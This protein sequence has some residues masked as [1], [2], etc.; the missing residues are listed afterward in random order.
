[1]AQP[2]KV[3]D[4]IKEL[5]RVLAKDLKPS[6]LNWRTHSEAQRS[7]MRGILAEIGYAGAALA[8]ELPDGGLELIDGHLRTETTPDMMI[9]VL[10]LDVSQEEAAKILATFDPLG[11]L[12]GAD[13]VALEKLLAE[14]NVHDPAL[15]AMLDDVAA[16]AGLAGDSDVELKPVDVRPPPAMT[17]ALIGIP[18][19]R[20]GEIAEAVNMLGSVPGIILETTSND[21]RDEG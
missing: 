20:F 18:T 4:R 11:T 14:V 9:P 16:D 7:A 19:V 13:A 3:R 5:R 10:V 2:L 21:G 12:A 8:R 1:M 17:W 6:P 15:Q